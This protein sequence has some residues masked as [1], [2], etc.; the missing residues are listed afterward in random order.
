MTSSTNT[1]ASSTRAR[2]FTLAVV[3][4]AFGL[5]TT[6]LLVGV[7]GRSVTGATAT[8]SESALAALDPD[9]VADQIAGW[10]ASEASS[11]PGVP[12]PTVEAVVRSVADSPQARVAIESVVTDVVAAAAAPAGSETVIDVAAAIEPLRPVLIAALEQAGVEASAAEVDGFLRQIGQ[13]VLSSVEHNAPAGS[14]ATARSTLTTVMLVGAAGLAVFGVAALRLS[15]DR[16]RMMRSLANRLIVSSL[17]FALFLRIGAWAVDPRGGRSPLRESGAIL[18]ASN[19]TTVLMIAAAGVVVSGAMTLGIRRVKSR[20]V[21]WEPEFSSSQ[22]N[23][24][25]NPSTQDSLP[26]RTRH[27]A[28][29]R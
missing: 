22:P 27:R 13:L 16:S 5:A 24:P 14:I 20:R 21:G 10:L 19:T 1:P 17:T 18:L 29:V 15:D 2:T 7:W 12:E 6:T 25:V 8:L 11:L 3:L 26:D 28:S 9:I 4:W 23:D